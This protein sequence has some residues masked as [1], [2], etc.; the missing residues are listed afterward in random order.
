MNRTDRLISIVLL[1]H[2][3]KVVRA[4]D[5]AAQFNIALR[6]V[7]RDMKA[8]NEAGVPI[9]A[10]AG[11]GYSLAAGYHLPPVMFT[12]DEASA[13]ALGAELVESFTDASFQPHIL[14]ALQ[15]VRAVLPEDKKEYL[16]KITSSLRIVEPQRRRN[17][18]SG[19]DLL[20]GFQD[21]IVN[22]R[23]IRVTYVNRE[24]EETKRAVEPLGLVFYSDFWH[25]IGFCRL[26]NDYRDFRTDRIRNAVILDDAFTPHPEFSLTNYLEANRSLENPIEVRVLFLNPIATLVRD[27]YYFGLVHEEKIDAGV[28]LTFVTPDLKYLTGWLL[29]FG[30]HAEVLEPDALK[31][32]L[33]EEAQ[34]LT[35]ILQRRMSKPY[36]NG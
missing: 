14:T 17:T 35:A 11:E 30:E 34:K 27:R 10:E 33:V 26:R 31:V 16:E 15:K 5:I 2:S 28:I 1:L 12:L 20:R 18:R 19:E 22:R 6:T 25:L 23:V 9:A 3:R 24:D 13:L 36:N 21:A 8:L 4:R 32:L 7:Y 29:S